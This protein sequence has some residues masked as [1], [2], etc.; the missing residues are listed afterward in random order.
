MKLK[1][2]FWI[3]SAFTLCLFVGA[4]AQNIQ[5][6]GK[7]TNKTNGE[8]LVGASVVVKETNKTTLTD[9]K[10]NFTVSIPAKGATVVVSYVGMNKVEKKVSAAGT[11]NF[12]LTEVAESNLN[13]VIVVGYGTQKITNVSGAISTIKSADIEK[14]NAVRTEEALQGRASGVSVIQGGSP[15]SKPT[16]L[17]RGIPSFTGTD[18]TVIAVLNCYFV[19]D[20]LCLG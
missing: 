15:G 18:P 5:V 19:K 16:V 8:L 13:E 2:R 6:G 11:V 10:G 9:A 4:F 12:E 1:L 14:V 3:T 17:I 20:P 7:V